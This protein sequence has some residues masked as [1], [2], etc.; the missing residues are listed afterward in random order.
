MRRITK[1]HFRLAL[2]VEAALVLGG[3]AATASAQSTIAQVAAGSTA[4]NPYT[5]NNV[6]VVG[7]LDNNSASTYTTP[8]LEDS[9]GSIVDFRVTKT[10]YVP[11]VGDIID[12][13]A[14]SSPFD[15]A[16]EL[17]GSSNTNLTVVSSGNAVPTPAVLTIPQFNAAIVEPNV[18]AIVT[19]DNVTFAAGTPTTLLGNTDYTLTDGTNTAVLYGYKS[20]TGTVAGLAAINAVG[21]PFTPMDITGYVDDFNGVTNLYPLSVVALPEPTSLSL[22]GIGGLLLARR[23]RR[24]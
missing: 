8:V 18:D 10:I 16:P 17:T 11:K 6:E 22:L 3:F 23:R 1:S 7:I 20:Y 14:N 13:T 21:S 2:A 15:G 9:T 4:S 24:A 19:L 12:V 5:L